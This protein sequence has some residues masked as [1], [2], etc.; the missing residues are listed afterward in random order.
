MICGEVYPILARAPLAPNC[1]GH[2]RCVTAF[3]PILV[4]CLR[5]NETFTFI[6]SHNLFSGGD[7]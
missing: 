2:N 3:T 5:A 1:W 4:N 6:R 7:F